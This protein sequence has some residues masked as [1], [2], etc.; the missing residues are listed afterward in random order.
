MLAHSADGVALATRVAYRPGTPADAAAAGAICYEAFKSIAGRHAFP[1]DFPSA[2]AAI[3]LLSQLFAR[4]DVS[5]VVAE[6]NGRV[7]GSN[8]LWENG[9]IAGVGPITID[10]AAQNGGVGRRLMLEVL[11]RAKQRGFAGVRLVQATY[12]SRSLSLY[13]KLGFDAREALSNVQ[14][15]PLHVAIPGCEVRAARAAD[16]DGC[17]ALCARIHGHGR[18][19]ELAEAIAHGSATVVERASRITGYAT[20]IGFFGHAVAETNDDLKALIGAADGFAGPG[21]LVPTRNGELLR[22]CLA[23]GLRVVQPLTL[24]SVGLYNEPAGAF[25]PS[26]IY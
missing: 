5:S 12:H 26:I 9:V 24:M 22:W 8:F 25:L 6:S 18:A 10:P 11:A 14:G 15:P 23:H 4:S 3:G 13:T 17:N 7:I 19:G 16:A 21:L 2:D 1:A 20:V